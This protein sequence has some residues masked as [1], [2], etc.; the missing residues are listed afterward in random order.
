MNGV[1]QETFL[2]LIEY[3][4]ELESQEGR[5]SWAGQIRKGYPTSW[6]DLWDLLPDF[7][8]EWF[9]PLL[10]PWSPQVRSDLCS[11]FLDQMN[12][13]PG[14]YV[15]RYTALTAYDGLIEYLT[16]SHWSKRRPAAP[17]LHLGGFVMTDSWE[18]HVAMLREDFKAVLNF[19]KPGDTKDWRE[20]QWEISNSCEVE[21]WDRAVQLYDR[22]SELQAVDET[23]MR[24]LL[25]QFRFL[26]AFRDAPAA[27]LQTDILSDNGPFL[28]K[29]DLLLHPS[30]W[31]RL[32]I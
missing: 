23:D 22:A 29:R 13:H 10:E 28:L 5:G 17:D 15:V 2:G 1:V 3:A 31:R 20:I 24:L 25:G 9:N 12:L 32:S 21:D 7:W 16:S 26:L 18:R 4:R 19:V 8:D 30:N 14:D 11:F 6:V 27:P